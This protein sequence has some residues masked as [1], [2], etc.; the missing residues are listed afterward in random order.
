MIFSKHSSYTASSVTLLLIFST[1][2]QSTYE[3]RHEEF[4]DDIA[5]RKINL[6]Q[7]AGALAAVVMQSVVSI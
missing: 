7:T 6:G 1:Y 2:A 3:T 5:N 4:Y